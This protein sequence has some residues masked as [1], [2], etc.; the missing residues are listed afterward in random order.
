MT[1]LQQILGLTAPIM[2][3]PMA[4]ASDVDFVLAANRAGILGSLG[5]GMMSPSAINQAINGI[6]QQTD[7]PFNVNLMILDD[8][9]SQHFSAPMPSWL[10]NFY[11]ELG[12]VATLG[13]TP[14][15]RF[16]EQLAVLL[17]N[18]VPVASFTFGIL[19][20][21]QMAA[22]QAVG[23]LVIGTANG[24]DEVLAWQA[25]GADAVVV[26]G[27][28]AG[29]HQG[30]WLKSA[31]LSALELLVQA[32][33]AADVPLI[34]AGG[35]GT[36][37]QVGQML[38]QGADLVAVG[39]LFLTTDE[40]PIS[41]VWQQRL[42]AATGDD[43]RLTRLFSGKMARGIIN[44]YMQR[45]A[46]LDGEASADVLTYPTMNAMTKALRAYGN[47]TANADLMSLWAGTAVGH[48]RRQSMAQ[49]VCQL[50]PSSF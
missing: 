7:K 27:T 3:A 14:A 10:E 16:D 28:E 5:A 8:T 43:T 13:K 35:I 32:K 44:D 21:A 48:C 50:M 46:H 38:Q 17:D 34:V 22:L 11:Q 40:A 6:K 29:G 39:T 20:K 26:Q 2:Q 15:Q 19:N 42:L 37:A 25:L 4:G 47:Q 41:P 9:L 30:G 24:V 23:S 49:L 45:F 33:A 31:K 18:P 12:I 1:K 36:K